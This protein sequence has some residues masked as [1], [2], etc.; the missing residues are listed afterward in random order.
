[1]TT[2]KQPPKRSKEWAAYQVYKWEIKNRK[3]L[4]KTRINF[5]VETQM[6]ETLD[7]HLALITEH[8][9]LTNLIISLFP[10]EHVNHTPLGLLVKTKTPPD[11]RTEGIIRPIFRMPEPVPEP[12]SAPRTKHPEILLVEQRFNCKIYG[13][14]VK[15]IKNGW[16][17]LNMTQTGYLYALTLEQLLRIAPH[18]AS[19]PIEHTPRLLNKTPVYSVAPPIVPKLKKGRSSVLQLFEQAHNGRFRNYNTRLNK[20]SWLCLSYDKSETL[21]FD[22]L[23]ELLEQCPWTF[24]L[25]S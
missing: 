4:A 12:K 2:R 8:L 6:W 3:N 18:I 22:T 21:V 23:D 24:E 10:K 1:M 16:R 7:K 5:R 20:G 19:V 9:S 25:S 17:C 13:S 15:P 11:E 14:Q